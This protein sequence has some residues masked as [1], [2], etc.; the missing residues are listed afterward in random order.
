MQRLHQSSPK[1]NSEYEDR[2]NN[3]LPNLINGIKN[4]DVIRASSLEQSE[5]DSG[6]R[7]GGINIMNIKD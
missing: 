5:D 4:H 3:S 6:Q 1:Y 2:M 7:A